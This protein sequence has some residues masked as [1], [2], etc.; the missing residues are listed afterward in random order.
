MTERDLG[1]L[2]ATLDVHVHEGVWA[3]RSGGASPGAV[4]TFVEREGPCF[5]A[6]ATADTPD[7]NR[8]T[9]LELTV[10][11]DLNAVG[12]LARV[13]GALANAG[14]PCNAIAG[15]NHDHIFVPARSAGDAKSALMALVKTA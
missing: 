4:F 14:I 8:W 5:I 1:T 11:S 3:Y 6:P 10:Y 12:F 9:W 13:A 7:E 2:L 15:L